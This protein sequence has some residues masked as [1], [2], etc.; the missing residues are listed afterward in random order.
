M[1]ALYTGFQHM[2]SWFSSHVGGGDPGISSMI[3]FFV[4]MGII[5][6]GLG[7]LSNVL[8]KRDGFENLPS[9]V[10]LVIYSL[11][12]IPCLLN[13]G[14]EIL[15]RKKERVPL[16][17]SG[18]FLSLLVVYF[19]L[20]FAERIFLLQ[21]G[22]SWLNEPIQL[23]KQTILA[24]YQ[25]LNSLAKYNSTSPFFLGG[26]CESSKG[27]L[28]ES[29]KPVFF[30]ST[31]STLKYAGTGEGSSFFPTQKQNQKSQLTSFVSNFYNSL[32]SP[33]EG[34]KKGNLCAK[35]PHNLANNQFNYQYALSGWFF[36][37]A[38]PPST[39]TSYNEFVS[40]LNFGT[41]PNILFRA[42]THTLRIVVPF[43]QKM[44][45]ANKGDKNDKSDDKIKTKKDM[46]ENGN[47]IVYES[48]DFQFQKWNHILVQ[49]RGGTL[50][51]F[52]NGQLVAS[53]NEVVPFMKYD[54]LTVGSLNGINGGVCNVLYF[55]KPLMQHQIQWMYR[56]NKMFSPP[57]LPSC[58]PFV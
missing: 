16:I 44:D 42:G 24:T 21:S 46:D 3:S 57:I 10:R 36:V 39:K 20:P 33:P 41:K 31:P 56:I 38:D 2:V 7:W 19:T 23:N 35:N 11:L 22:H 15:T 45:D 26:T 37:D 50:D 17:W 51:V 52:L 13:D 49:Q 58:W 30:E 55:R 8:M 54:V 43:N 12:Y 9:P 48:S 18:V 53:V 25:D 34:E 28:K 47:R 14:L 27:K 5:I 4:S 6:S 40:L 29:E 1:F 32:T